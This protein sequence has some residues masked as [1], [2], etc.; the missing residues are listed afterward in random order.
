LVASNWFPAELELLSGR[1]GLIQLVV[2]LIWKGE[3]SP[4]RVWT[5]VLSDTV[6]LHI[7][8]V[9]VHRKRGS[10]P[11]VFENADVDKFGRRNDTERIVLFLDK[12]DDRAS[13]F[14][15]MG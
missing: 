10:P 2:H 11:I 13:Q 7:V 5:L 9:A 3:T 6:P 15:R 8:V 12:N 14:R 1:S 4:D